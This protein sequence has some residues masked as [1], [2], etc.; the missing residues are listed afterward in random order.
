MYK[1]SVEPICESKAKLFRWQKSKKFFVGEKYTVSFKGKNIGDKDFPG[2]KFTFNINYSDGRPV[3]IWGEIKAVR[4][5]QEWSTEPWKTDALSKDYALF[6]GEITA[7]D[8]NPVELCDKNGQARSREKAFG[9]I[10]I[11][12]YA[13]VYSYYALIVSAFSL[14]ALVILSILQF[15]K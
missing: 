13:D 6:T 9:S 2:G 1:F 11:Q 12:T 4:A 15:F 8:G 3:S 7:N 5:G 14:V 10:F